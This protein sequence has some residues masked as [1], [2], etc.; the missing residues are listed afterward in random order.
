MHCL[1]LMFSLAVYLTNY[2]LD[3]CQCWW[4]F[5]CSISMHLSRRTVHPKSCLTWSNVRRTSYENLTVRSDLGSR[6]CW[7]SRQRPITTQVI[8]S[9]LLLLL[10][11]M[12]TTTRMMMMKQPMILLW[13]SLVKCGI[14]CCFWFLFYCSTYSDSLAS[15]DCKNR[16]VPFPG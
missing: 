1:N 12:M 15:H 11:M 16:P 10:L 9:L 8:T 6:S 13:V 7:W 14:W 5:V 2:W 4:Y 3:G